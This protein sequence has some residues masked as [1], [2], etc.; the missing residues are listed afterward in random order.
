MSVMS[1]YKLGV[2][3]S[4][5]LAV[6]KRTVTVGAVTCNIEMPLHGCAASLWQEQSGS[7]LKGDQV[8]MAQG[9]LTVLGNAGK[10]AAW[11]PLKSSLIGLFIFQEDNPTI[12][13]R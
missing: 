13:T 6:L 9:D 4:T 11:E 3:L 8:P 7:V 5:E 10:K 1:D 2:S 12:L